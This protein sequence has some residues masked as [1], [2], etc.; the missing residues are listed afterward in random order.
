MR[1]DMRDERMRPWRKTFRFVAVLALVVCGLELLSVVAMLVHD[2][3]G[4][5]ETWGKPF[6]TLGMFI[7]GQMALTVLLAWLAWL[8]LKFTRVDGPRENTRA[9][10]G[11]QDK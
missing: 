2:F 10:D 6:G 4:F 8:S 5:L 11:E 7:S 9:A 3:R 1:M